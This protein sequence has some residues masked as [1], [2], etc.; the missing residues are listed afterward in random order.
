[1]TAGAPVA[2]TDGYHNKM[3]MGANGQLFVGSRNC[4]NVNSGSEIRG[5]L[6]IVNTNSGISVSGV[7]A[8]EDNGD[9]TGI[10][11]IPNRSVVYVCEGGKLRIYDTTTDR[12][13]VLTTA[14]TISGQA[15]DAKVVD[16]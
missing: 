10:A 15:I 3:E 9:V 4:S 7:I 1:V 11:P 8:P 6:S 2:I 5:C 12:L 14:P 16:F 13:E